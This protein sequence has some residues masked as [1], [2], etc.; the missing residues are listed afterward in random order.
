[1]SGNTDQD[2]PFLEQLFDGSDGVS[3]GLVKTVSLVNA[4]KQAWFNGISER[5]VT[6]KSPTSRQSLSISHSACSKTRIQVTSRSCFGVAVGVALGGKLNTHDANMVT[7][8][9]LK[10]FSK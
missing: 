6:T 9:H 10:I 5:D 8:D 1:M 3:S 7:F 4:L 2:T